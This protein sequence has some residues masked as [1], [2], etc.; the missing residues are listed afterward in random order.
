MLVVVAGEGIIHLLH[1]HL[2]VV[3]VVDIEAQILI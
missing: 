1:Q 3:V 2:V